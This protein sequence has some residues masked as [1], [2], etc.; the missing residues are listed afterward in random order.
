MPGTVELFGWIEVEVAPLNPANQRFAITVERYAYDLDGDPIAAGN[1]G[2][3]EPMTATL[4]LMG[5]GVFGMGK[6][7]R[8]AQSKTRQPL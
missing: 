3:P 8:T 4:V 5:L 6:R 7:R 1:T 2:V